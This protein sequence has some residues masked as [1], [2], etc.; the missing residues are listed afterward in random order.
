MRRNA[1]LA[2]CV[3]LAALALATCGDEG[4][5]T[6]DSAG[7]AEATTGRSDNEGG[8]KS[9]ENFGTEAEGSARAAVLAAFSDYLNG[10][11]TKD[12]PRACSGLAATVRASLEQFA[13]AKL[14]AKGCEG[15]L[16]KLLAP[17]AALIAAEQAAGKVTRV[18]VQ[19]DRAFVIF[20]SP[21]AKLYQLPM[22]REGGEWKAGLVAASIRIPSAATLGQ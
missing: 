18:R 10:I 4:S 7:P 2:L 1:A 6:Q 8:E 5:S 22:A 12:Y 3:A 11:A 14:K 15:I 20:H 19:G 9:I 13:S 17:T 21:G 16:P